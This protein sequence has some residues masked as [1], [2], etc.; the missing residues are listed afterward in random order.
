MKEFDVHLITGNHDC[1]FKNTND[2]NSPDL[3]LDYENIKTYSNATEIN[4][5]AEIF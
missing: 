4:V 3:L 1:Y 5:T 2:T